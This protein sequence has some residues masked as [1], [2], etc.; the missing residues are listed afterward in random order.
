MTITQ[1]EYIVALNEYQS[2]SKAA[3]YCCVT[4]PSLSMQIQKLEDEL[5]LI[6]FN[7]KIKPII[8]T[9]EGIQVINAARKIIQEKKT[10]QVF[11]KG[12]HKDVIGDVSIGIIPTIA[13]YLIPKF[14]SSFKLNY[15]NL[16]LNIFET[17]TENIYKGINEGKLDMGI[18]VPIDSQDMSCLTLFYEE[19]FLYSN[20][21]SQTGEID[22]TIIPEKL[23]IL[24]E[25]HCLSNQIAS[26]CNLRNESISESQIIYKTG[27][28]ETMLR[29]A[30][31]GK[32]QTIIPHMLVDYL[33]ESTKKKIF[34]ITL[35]TPV[36][37][38][39]LIY[40]ENYNRKGIINALKEEILS[41]IPLEWISSNNKSIIPLNI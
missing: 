23:W 12:Y 2:F 13:P 9:K 21:T 7:R 34:K 40:S 25:G 8:P 19:L 38:I 20:V 6:I 22:Q 30:E 37:E 15:P 29:L 16:K 32:G 26:I 14:L 4:Q 5:N 17:T 35:N 41:V 39:A 33:N 1:L 28:L 3:K 27:S 31:N 10:I 36:R 24:E 11:A 18:L